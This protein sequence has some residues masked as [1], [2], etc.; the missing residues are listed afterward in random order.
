MF[1]FISKLWTKE[2]LPTESKSSF[3]PEK[4]TV[5][6]IESLEEKHSKD[7]QI[8]IEETKI[9]DFPKGFVGV[10]LNS[11]FYSKKFCAT[12]CQK[13]LI[14]FNALLEFKFESGELRY[15]FFR[16]VVNEGNTLYFYCLKDS[17]YYHSENV[18]IENWHE[19]LKVISPNSPRYLEFLS[20]S[21]EG[22]EMFEKIT[23]KLFPE[24]VNDLMELKYYEKQFSKEWEEKTKIL[25]FCNKVIGQIETQLTESINICPKPNSSYFQEINIEDNEYY[26]TLS[27][28]NKDYLKEY[29][30]MHF[31]TTL[32][33]LRF[34]FSYI[35]FGFV[36]RLTFK[37]VFLNINFIYK[38]KL[39]RN[40]AFKLPLSIYE[41]SSTVSTK[42]LVKILESENINLENLDSIQEIVIY[43][44]IMSS[45][46]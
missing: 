28:E 16:G 8:K 15:C 6:K 40:N 12:I 43:N 41:N 39:K 19:K 11:S 14:P 10:V 45:K 22:M 2:S 23:R 42:D 34:A 21:M 27:K 29:I 5:L 13:T 37:P 20:R 35:N 33:H 30:I 36:F 31:A 1:N 24:N 44:S 18:T 26:E 46:C 4:E 38:Y 7:D 32:K 9:S 17:E 25:D 3:E